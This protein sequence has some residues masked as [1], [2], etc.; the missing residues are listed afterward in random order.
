MNVQMKNAEWFFFLSSLLLLS[1]SRRSRTGRPIHGVSAR[2]ASTADA[3]D[4]PFFSPAA[5]MTTFAII[6]ANA[7]NGES[8]FSFP[9]VAISRD[10]LRAALGA[11]GVR[12]ATAEA[13][14]SDSS[15]RGVSGRG[16][17]RGD[18][19]RRA[20]I[21]TVDL[22][23]P[24]RFASGVLLRVPTEVGVAPATASATAAVGETPSASHRS[25]AAFP[26]EGN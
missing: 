2:A 17:L 11:T 25:R 19:S 23:N 14:H 15:P 20:T 9:G 8:L 7:D 26:G 5:S 10:I 13:D 18:D 1:F 21:S 4:D 3:E 6:L 24:E 22:V 16:A 12:E